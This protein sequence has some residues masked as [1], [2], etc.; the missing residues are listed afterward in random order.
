MR[1]YLFPVVFFIVLLGLGVTVLVALGN[2]AQDVIRD[3]DQIRDAIR[4]EDWKLAEDR[5]AA[6]HTAWDKHRQWWAVVIDHREIDNIEMSFSKVGEYIRYQDKA[7]A[8]AELTV[9]KRLIEHIPEKEKVSL[10]N[11]L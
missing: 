1:L 6:A 7:M 8:S 3:F 2:S 9:L 10:K 5:I 11:I 4:N